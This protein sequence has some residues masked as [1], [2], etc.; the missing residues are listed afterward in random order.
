MNSLR[1][2]LD[3]VEQR[4]K[5]IEVYT[6]DSDVVGDLETQFSTRNVSVVHR[7]LPSG[8]DEGFVIIRD[9]DGSFRR[10]MGLDQFE[11][12]LS[13]D[14]DLPWEIA[15][16]ETSLADVF[17]FLDNT[18]FS[19]FDRRQML[20][21]SREIEERAWRVGSGRL[22]VGFQNTRAVT[23][24]RG[25]Y[26]TFARESEVSPTLF[27]EDE[28]DSDLDDRIRVERGGSDDIGRFWFVVFDGDGDDGY[29]CALLAEERD[30]GTY[31]GFWTYEPDTVDEII[32]DLDSL[33]GDRGRPD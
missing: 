25:V 23:A 11:A 28:L 15:A 31:Y 17:D 12:I 27:L 21:V 22:L 30:P 5:R 33:A 16:T 2:R 26:E 13:P 19:T 1:E 10:T 8:E 9:G 18:V 14:V 20:A 29:K 32:T 3:A 6:A 4:R 7:S 24:Q